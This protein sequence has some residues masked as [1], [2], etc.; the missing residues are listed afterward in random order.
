[1]FALSSNSYP[2]FIKF[3]TEYCFMIFFLEVIA[4]FV[5]IGAVK[6]TVYWRTS[7]N[8]SPIFSF[9]LLWGTIHDKKMS[10][11]IHRLTM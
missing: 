11:K 5:I 9:F 4:S 3:C 2:F 8:I 10:T 1:M 7:K 6:T